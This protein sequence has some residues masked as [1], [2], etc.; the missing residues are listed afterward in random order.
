V[1]R[2]GKVTHLRCQTKTVPLP[3]EVG[4]PVNVRVQRTKGPAERAGLW[5]RKENGKAKIREGRPEEAA[6][7]IDYQS[8]SP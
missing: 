2:L 7:R 8:G 5:N 1:T 4:E 6:S 3:L